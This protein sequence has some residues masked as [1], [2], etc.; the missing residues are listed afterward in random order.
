MNEWIDEWMSR[1]E[2]AM[3]IQSEHS[4]SVSQILMP[5]AKKMQPV[6]SWTYETS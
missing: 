4:Q 6:Q 3:D 5:P 1:L 2:E